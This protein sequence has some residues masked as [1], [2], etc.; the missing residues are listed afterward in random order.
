MAHCVEANTWVDYILLILVL[1]LI[2]VLCYSEYVAHDCM[3]HKTCNHRIESPKDSDDIE[4]KINQ[5]IKMIDNNQDFVAWR[6]SLMSGL[7]ASVFVVYYLKGRFPKFHEYLF[8]GILV[9]IFVY[10]SWTWI[11]SHFFVP[12]SN[13]IEKNLM[14][15]SR[16][17][18]DAEFLNSRLS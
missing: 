13:Q 8:I 3:P 5:I 7:I 2:A 14:K 17:L 6:Q 10:F 16:Q 15:I 11:H 18:L 9:T 12:N 1:A 4:T